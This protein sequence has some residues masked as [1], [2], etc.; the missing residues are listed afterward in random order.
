MRAFKFG[1]K[2]GI[3]VEIEGK[4]YHLTYNET[5]IKKFDKMNKTFIKGMQDT[6]NQNDNDEVLKE[7][8][9][10]A[11]GI[12]D[13]ILGD[14]EFDKIFGIRGYDIVE[15]LELIGYL[16]EAI[17]E[18]KGKIVTV[19][20]SVPNSKEK[21]EEVEALMASVTGNNA[22]GD[23]HVGIYRRNTPLG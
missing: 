3:D 12:V 14:G 2:T 19:N 10:A 13:T 11:R 8:E 18:L 1:E 22:V 6:L 7:C 21:K 23:A 16:M 17:N 4:T 5:M 15:E 9:V 20:K